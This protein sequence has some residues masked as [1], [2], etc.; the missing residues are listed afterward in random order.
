MSRGDRRPS[1]ELVL[2]AEGHPD[3]HREHQE[4]RPGGKDPALLQHPV[5]Q[6]P[7]VV[8]VP[9]CAALLPRELTVR[10]HNGWSLRFA[11]PHP[12]LRS[13]ARALRDRHDLPESGQCPRPVRQEIGRSPAAGSSR[14]LVDQ[15]VQLG[16]ASSGTARATTL[17]ALS[18]ATR[19]RTRRRRSC[20][21]RHS[22]RSAPGR[23]RRRRSCTRR[24]GRPAPSTTATAPELRTQ[25]RSPARPARRACRRSRRSRQVLPARTGS[26]RARRPAD[27]RI[28]ITPPPMP[29]P[30]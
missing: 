10:N 19:S 24:S 18:C 6:R 23:P 11:T 16:A 15:R 3:H 28:A 1:G 2:V 30:T 22:S 17:S 21:H 25:N 26:V 14:V 7:P 12:R 29:L 4:C 8:A 5:P 27:G 9:S 13:P 20:P